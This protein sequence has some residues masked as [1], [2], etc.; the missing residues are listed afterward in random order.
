MKLIR[1]CQLLN[2]WSIPRPQTK[3]EIK[4]YQ[5]CH[6]SYFLSNKKYVAAVFDAN[7]LYNDTLGEMA[8]NIYDFTIFH[9]FS[10]NSTWHE[11]PME[12]TSFFI[13]SEVTTSYASIR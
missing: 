7:A 10:D 13:D 2:I 4:F 6:K 9:S 5:F 1:T 12:G 11:H 8:T 3:C